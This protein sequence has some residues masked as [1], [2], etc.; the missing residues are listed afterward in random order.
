MRFAIVGAGAIGGFLGAKLSV[1]GHEVFLIARGPHLQAM[2]A[3]GVRVHS[4]DGD[5]E[6]H[7]VAT[8][9]F[10]EVG[11]VDFVFL[12][13]KAHSLAEV[14]PKL[15]PMLGPDTALVSAQ[16]GI[17]WW[18][19]QRHG[20]PWEGTQLESLDPGGVVSRAIE[21]DRIIGCVVYPSTSIIEPGVI[22]H[23]EGSRF[24]IGELDG[25]TTERCRNL[26]GALIESGLRCPIR[27]RI[28]HE[29]WVKLLGNLAFNPIS[30]LTHATLSEIATHPEARTVARAAMEEA[31]AVARGLGVTIPVSVDQR[32]AGAE[33]VGH[34]KTS[35]LQ[36]VE[37][38]KPIE[39]ESVVGAVVELGDKLG[40]PMPY[41]KTIYACAKLLAQRLAKGT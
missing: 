16:N 41:T 32:M 10:Q 14:A 13:V 3:Q 6:A 30:A 22:Q 36:D 29:L 2:R 11:A 34:H 20:G 1:S 23:I 38:G 37:A 31:D 7:P 19:F 18:Y 27:S 4:P 33:K 35:M 39:L 5:F 12:T 25:T 8:D 26:A 40:I 9:N 21:P 15:L 17:P 28:R 24:S